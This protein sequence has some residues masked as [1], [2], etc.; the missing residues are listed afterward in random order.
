MMIINIIS[1]TIQGI[2]NNE[3]LKEE[4]SEEK[5]K[6]IINNI[7]RN[8]LIDTKIDYSEI[9]KMDSTELV[10]YLRE[11]LLDEYNKKFDDFPIE[12]KNEFEKA[13]VLRVIDQNWMNHIDT[14]SNLRQ[15][16][17]LRAYA[18][19]NPLRAYTTEG[20]RLFEA[21]LN[22]INN[23]AALYLMKAQIRRNLE[24]KEIQKESCSI[25]EKSAKRQPRKV[26][27]W[28]Q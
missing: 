15:G 13:I 11:K 19:E 21:L 18:Q 22:K 25:E 23:E 1:T 20:F 12:V 16:I 4:L 27:E 17:H 6:N 7:N 5:K 26:N 10:S 8:Y 24:R 3:M 2:V 9:K 28:S 14:M